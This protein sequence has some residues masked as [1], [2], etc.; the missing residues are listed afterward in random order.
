MSEGRKKRS[1]LD[2]SAEEITTTGT[3]TEETD[4]KISFESW[5]SLRLSKKERKDWLKEPVKAFFTS[6]GLSDREEIK[7]YDNAFEKF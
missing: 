2:D 1:K 3:I 4:K 5:V 7:T 6:L